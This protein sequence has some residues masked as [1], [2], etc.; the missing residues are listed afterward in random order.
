M[1]SSLPQSNFNSHG[2]CSWC[3]TGFPNYT[4]HGKQSLVQKLQSIKGKG[5]NADCLVAISGGKDSSFAVYALRT[6]FAM[7]V[8]AFT[9]VH[10]GLTPFALKNAQGVCESVNVPHHTVSLTG[11]THLNLFREYFAAWCKCEE[12]VTAAMTCVACKH[13]HILGMRLAQE[14]QIPMIVWA[15]CPLETPPF[16]PTQKA[17]G[18]AAESQG[19]ASLALS[20]SKTL[21]KESGFRK[22]FL[23]AIQ[24]NVMGCLAFR[25][26][27]RV[28]RALYPGVEQLN[29]F[30]YYPWNQHEMRQALT[31]D[32]TW[33]VDPSVTTD[34]HSDCV[35]N[36][37]KEYMYQK[38][39]GA[40]YTDGFLS[41]QIRHGILTREEGLHQLASSK[42][43]FAGQL[44]PALEAVGLSHLLRRCDTSCFGN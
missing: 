9:Y 8:E 20:L 29:F 36:V 25:P 17:G 11:H 31:K 10:D 34:W 1:P 42:K 26:G 37:F 21:L 41:N 19:V 22:T 38:M 5:K 2:E 4:P 28:F 43:Y 24:T 16:I 12:P 7:K 35:F 13:L 30:D 33:T 23:G 18:S 32:T 6:R 44:G 14:R 15:Y 40:S 27:N 39:L 3:Q